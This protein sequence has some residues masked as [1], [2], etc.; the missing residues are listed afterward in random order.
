MKLR[1]VLSVLLLLPWQNYR[2]SCRTP[3][4]LRRRALSENALCFV[5]W[6]G[7]SEGSS[8]PFSPTLPRDLEAP[9]TLP[10]AP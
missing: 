6:F 9:I 3:T 7:V 2:P 1:V 4:V 10:S 8:L 5:A